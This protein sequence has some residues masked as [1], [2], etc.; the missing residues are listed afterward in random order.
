MAQTRESWLTTISE[1]RSSR[2]YLP[3]LELP[4]SWYA[5]NTKTWNGRILSEN[6]RDIVWKAIFFHNGSKYDL[7]A[8]V[9][10][11]DHVHL[12]LHPLVKN[13]SGYYSLREIFHS[14]K[15][16]SAME[17][18]KAAGIPTRGQ[19]RTRSEDV[20]RGRPTHIHPAHRGRPTN[21]S[22]RNSFEHKVWQ[23]EYFDHLIRDDRDYRS[24]F[25]YLIYNPMEAGLVERPEDYRWLWYKGMEIPQIQ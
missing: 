4:G 3:H 23:D 13:S 8:V 14:I 7:D 21:N 22:E 10:M 1:F 12:I 15:S 18:L 17:I 16:Y 19:D 2:G 24:N 25:L 5:A 6:D 20:G 9:V 11:P